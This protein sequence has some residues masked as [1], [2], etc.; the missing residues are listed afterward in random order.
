[1]P[2]GV[3][4]EVGFAMGHNKPVIW[5]CAKKEEKAVHFDTRQYNHIFWE[6]EQQLYEELKD[7]ILGTIT[8]KE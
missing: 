6:N 7:R 5:C 2:N 4:F 1:M 3:Y 8:I